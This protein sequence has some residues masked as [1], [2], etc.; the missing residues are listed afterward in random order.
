MAESIPLPYFFSII[1]SDRWQSIV[2][3]CTRT[4][5]HNRIVVIRS[6]LIATIIAFVEI[7]FLILIN[8]I[9]IDRHIVIS[10][11]STLF[12]QVACKKQ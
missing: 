10:V 5:M 3:K 12:M 1:C 4:I 8:I 2:R 7:M 6:I 9:P 11:I